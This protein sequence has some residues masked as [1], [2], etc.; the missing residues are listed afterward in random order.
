GGLRTALPLAT[1][2]GRVHGLV[3][4]AVLPLAVDGELGLTSRVGAHA[5]CL[6]GLVGSRQ[7]A[8]G[9]PPEP[10]VRHAAHIL[11]A[12]RMRAPGPSVP[13]SNSTGDR[14]I[15]GLQRRGQVCVTVVTGCDRDMTRT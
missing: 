4:P 7:V 6:V 3:L 11:S 9:C 8:D 1:R 14:F 10:L 2:H 5:A 13:S 12:G 15:P